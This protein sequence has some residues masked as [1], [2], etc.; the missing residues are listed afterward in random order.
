MNRKYFLIY[1]DVFSFKY[2]FNIN[3]KNSRISAADQSVLKNNDSVL[4]ENNHKKRADRN[5]D[6]ESRKK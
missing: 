5:I 2:I 4:D 1:I 3:D 6:I